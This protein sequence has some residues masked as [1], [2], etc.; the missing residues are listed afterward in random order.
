MTELSEA[1]A[2][3]TSAPG[4]VVV[5]RTLMAASAGGWLFS[6]FHVPLGWLLGALFATIVGTR[7]FSAVHIPRLMRDL[8]SPVLGV[9]VGS[10][11]TPALLRQIGQ[12]PLP[13]AVTLGYAALISVLGFLYFRR[14]ARLDVMTALFAGLP[15]GLSEMTLL[16][17]A[18]GARANVLAVVHS[19]RIVMIVVIMPFI[20]GFMARPMPGAAFA[21][22]PPLETI[23]I[24]LLVACGVGGFALSRAV[25]MPAGALLLPLGLSATVHLAGVTGGAPPLWIVAPAQ[26]VVGAYIGVRFVGM[27]FRH[28]LP[29]VGHGVTWGFIMIGTA[30]G[31]A[32]L[33]SR[34]FEGVER[35][36]LLLA[37]SPGG[38][39]EMSLLTLS[40]G[41][42]VAF[43]ITCHMMRIVIVFLCAPAIARLVATRCNRS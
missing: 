37:L 40:V 26:I 18:L 22:K 36:P 41:V 16:G 27:A 35:L 7:L 24:V 9:L 1:V 23:D 43:V 14:V 21:G 34:V 30:V 33:T 28:V 11:F 29:M 17:V 25:R 4:H 12:W 19:L 32:I 13:V 8:V 38:M 39:S 31:L 10:S 20:I 5:L 6:H 15:G 3:Q 2:N 42:D